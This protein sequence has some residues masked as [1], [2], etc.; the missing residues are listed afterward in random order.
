MNLLEGSKVVVSVDG[1]FYPKKSYLVVAHFVI[2]NKNY[3]IGS[4]NFISTVTLKYRNPFTAELCRV[5][6]FL[7]AIDYVLIKYKV[8]AQNITI[9]ISSDY[10]SILDMLYNTSLVINQS[11]YLNQVVREIHSYWQK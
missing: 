10:K 4:S 8:K 2:Y 7:V 11:K 1:S 3:K 9:T 6:A 5:L